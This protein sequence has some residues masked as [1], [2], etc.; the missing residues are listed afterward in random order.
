[1][2]AKARCHTPT[3]KDFHRYGA[4][5]IIVCARWRSDFAA[6]FADMGVAPAG[7]SLDRIDVN[8]H[9]EPGN[10]RWATNSQQQRNKRNSPR[11]RIEGLA[12][13]T[14]SDAAAHFGVS[15]T[16]INRWCCGAYDARRARFTP[17]RPGAIKETA[18]K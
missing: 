17:A 3:N 6:F 13:E 14:I 4:R 9:Y 18:Y 5:G 15:P 10:C 12:F 16:T 1:M 7:H 2:G 11:V 8:G